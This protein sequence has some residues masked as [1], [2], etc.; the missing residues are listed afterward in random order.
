MKLWQLL[1]V[2]MLGMGACAAANAADLP[3]KAKAV[4]YVKVCAAYGAGY[5]YVPGTD[6]CLRLGGFVRFDAYVNAVGT[7]NPMI[8][9]AAGTAFSAPGTGVGGYPLNT[10]KADDYMTRVRTVVDLDARTATDYGVLRSF[11]RFGGQWD[12]QAAAGSPAGGSLYLERA[13]IQFAG[14]TFGYTQSFF[15]TG[16]DYMLTIPYA[17]SNTWTSAIAYTAQFGNGFSATIA[18]ED[19]ANRT[20]GVQYGP[21][22]G[23]FTGGSTLTG[24]NGLRYNNYQDGQQ[25][26]DV[27]ANLRL[28][29]DWGTALLS[30]ALH[31]VAGLTPAGVG[32]TQYVGAAGT[33][34]WGFALGGAL[35]IKLPMLAPGDSFYLQAN[36]A[37]GAL[38][39]LGL[40]GTQQGRASALGSVDLNSPFAASSGAYYPIADAIW[41]GNGYSK[42]TGWSIQGQFRHFWMPNLRS[43][44]YAGYVKVDVP[45]NATFSA[46]NVALLPGAALFNGGY[47]VNVTQV[48]LNTVW[49][50]VK[51]L[52]LGLEV[53]YSKV[54]GSL[55][56][57]A[58][59][60]SGTGSAGTL[61]AF[62][63]STDVWSGGFRAQRNF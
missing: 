44:L 1:P 18:L 23:T 50:P 48:G 20:T 19:A 49:S 27:V 30:G 9:S 38:N 54:D 55:P 25:A 33:D 60:I 39:Y 14:F 13:F 42:E 37:D 51:N 53:L 29:Q 6:T 35:E 8:S 7:F 43:A 59:L 12:S 32:G 47:S 26:P 11:V 5:Y 15:D 28:D 46:A 34:S 16:T 56:A 61:T 3:V 2:S 41:N 58:G 40:A 22:S 31:Q 45:A 62:G 4:E 36:Y 52:D 21:S 10:E 63:G 17:G 57:T 24:L